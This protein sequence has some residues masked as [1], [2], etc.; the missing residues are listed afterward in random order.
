[1]GIIVQKFGGSSVADATKIKN[2]AKRIAL[3]REGGHAVV[4]AV[5]AMGDTTDNLIR[6]AHE[7]S[8]D[9]PE[10][11]LDMLLSTGEQVSIALL[12]MAVSELGH[13]AISL[14][15]TQ[16]GII[17]SGFYSNARIQSINKERILSEL[18]RGRI[19]TGGFSGGNH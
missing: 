10:R 4:V 14:T 2:V 12:A 15:G 7:I 8:I 1:M 11:E 19:V 18:E 9:P 17:T 3:T 6:L 5:S 16:V 13:Q